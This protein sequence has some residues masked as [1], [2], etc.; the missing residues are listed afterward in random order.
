MTASKVLA[1]DSAWSAKAHISTTVTAGVELVSAMTAC[2][3]VADGV[4]VPARS[5]DVD[6]RC[7]HAGCRSRWP[8]L[9]RAVS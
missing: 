7:A 1:V 5:I 9:L 2:G 3:V 4:L 6:R 8:A